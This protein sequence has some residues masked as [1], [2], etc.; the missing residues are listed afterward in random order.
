[1]PRLV[2]ACWRL[3]AELKIDSRTLQ[4]DAQFATDVDLITAH[5]GEEVKDWILSRDARLTRRDVAHLALLGPADQRQA[6]AQLRREGHITWSDGLED[7][8]RRITVPV[9]PEALAGA[10]LRRL[11]PERAAAVLQALMEVL[12][13]DEPG[14][15]E[16]MQ[17]AP[18]VGRS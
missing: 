1:M 5:C 7:D 18:P 2:L 10:L 8:A 15:G 14:D 3:A 12:E 17:N 11:G 9:Q 6:I 13:M 16:R 4:R